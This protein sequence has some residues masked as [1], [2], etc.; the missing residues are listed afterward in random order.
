MDDADAFALIW[1]RENV[2][3]HPVAGCVL[4]DRVPLKACCGLLVGEWCDCE[5]FAAEAAGVFELLREVHAGGTAVLMATH[6]AELVAR[7]GLRVIALERGR[8]VGDTGA[9]A[10]D[11]PVAVG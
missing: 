4:C 11:T 6:S 10:A 2:H 9:P 5:R 8:V 3:L 7:A 1:H